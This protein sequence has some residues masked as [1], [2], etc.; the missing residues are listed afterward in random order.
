MFVR[1]GVPSEGAAPKEN[2][3][4]QNGL[5]R[6]HV[7]DIQRARILSAMVEVCVERGV[8]N[9]TVAHVV[10]RSGVSRRT[11]YELFADREECFMAALDG[12]I[13]SASTY[14]LPGYGAGGR[15][16]DRIRTALTGLLEFLEEEP[17]MGRLMVVETLGAGAVALRRRQILALVVAAVDDGRQEARAGHSPPSLTAE[18]VVGGVLSVLQSRLTEPGSGRL[19]ELTGSLMAMIVLPYLGPAASRQELQKPVPTRSRSTRRGMPANPLRDLEMRLTYRTIRVL[20]SVATH[21]GSSNREVGLAADI[22]DQGQISK[23]LTRLDK[24]GLIEN[25]GSGQTRGAPNA[26]KLTEKGA[27]IEAAVA[28]RLA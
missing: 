8:A 10:A 20:T 11:F 7:S 26:W 14:V 3:R 18:G 2:I 21:P 6:G 24:L 4:P 15:W 12:A 23:L 28:G 19:L 5:E 22:R 25:T 13:E 9:V 16:R 1:E 27:Q 17:L